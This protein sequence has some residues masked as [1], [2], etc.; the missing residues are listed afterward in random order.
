MSEM[1]L[2]PSTSDGIPSLNAAALLRLSI[3]VA[4]P[5]C[6]F[7][8][9]W[10][11]SVAHYYFMGSDAAYRATFIAPGARVIQHVLLLPLLCGCYFLAALWGASEA[12]PGRVLLKQLALLV[13]FSLLVRPVTFLAMH[14]G[15]R[16]ATEPL[17]FAHFAA[18]MDLDSWLS[19]AL[20]YS[21]V[22]ALG[23]CILFGLI[24]L[25]KYRREQLRAA[26]M[27]ANW[28][29]AQLETLRVQLHPHF[30]FNTLNTISALVGSRPEEARDLIAQ[31]A[32]LLRDSIEGAGGEFY[33]LRREVELA[34]KYLRIMSVR[35]GARLKPA[36]DVM[37]G[38]EDCPV[39]RG[40]LLTLL[41]NAVTH[42]VSMITGDSELSLRCGLDGELLL[43]EVGNRYDPDATAVA[44]APRRP[45]GSRHASQR[46]LRRRIQTRVRRRR[47]RYLVH[48]RQVAGGVRAPRCGAGRRRCASARATRAH[49]IRALIVDDEPPARAQVREFLSGEPDVLV[50][51]ES[52]DGEDALRQIRALAPDLLFMDIRM[53]RLSGLEVLSSGAEA[54]LPYTI[55]TT[56]YTQ[57]AVAAF[58]VEALDYLVKPLERERFREAVERAR[59]YLAR[60]AS[61]MRHI[62]PETLRAFLAS[63][64]SAAGGA[65]ERAPRAQGGPQGAV[66]RD[67]QHRIHW[68]RRRLRR[69]PSAGRRGGAARPRQHRGAAGA[70]AGSEIP[71]HPSLSDRQSGLHQ[72][73]AVQQAWAAIRSSLPADIV[74]R[75]AP[76]TRPPW[77]LSSPNDCAR[78]VAC[79]PNSGSVKFPP[80]QVS[81]RGFR[82]AAG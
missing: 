72:G 29:Q 64:Q 67:L 51:G 5:V 25:A 71:A 37:A 21:L 61:L 15:P 28:L 27:R 34:H 45:R 36:T 19:T 75:P 3:A 41:E 1:Q 76:P 60:D 16:G 4:V 23:L 80:S 33:P 47:R 55:F 17:D 70:P 77:K 49:V 81:R 52:A 7:A 30:L 11:L 82:A 9:L 48:A 68:R 56:A 59:R 42:G 79:A 43:V 12:R 53:P 66:P 32:A 46:A 13:A 26:A 73:A 14:L 20:N 24:V 44:G 78:P 22:Y 58:A 54:R 6:A 62:E 38:L 35:F 8:L 31:L 39:P 2:D 40:L 57:Y 10:N 65:R 74:S 69:D 50:I 63:L 18:A